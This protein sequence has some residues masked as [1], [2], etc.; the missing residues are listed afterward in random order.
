MQDLTQD[1]TQDRDWISDLI[2]VHAGNITIQ[3][4]QGTFRSNRLHLYIETLEKYPEIYWQGCDRFY[5]FAGKDTRRYGLRVVDFHHDDTH[6]DFLKS[7]TLIQFP[8]DWTLMADV[9]VHHVE[10]I[11]VRGTHDS[12]FKNVPFFQVGTFVE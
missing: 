11:G 3:S 1:L 10:V 5:L 4:I 12:A 6:A 7:A 2:T 9:N 8:P